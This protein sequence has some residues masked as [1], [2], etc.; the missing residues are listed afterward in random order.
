LIFLI[1][2]V[3]KPPKFSPVEWATTMAV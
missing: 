2:G 3:V 1:S